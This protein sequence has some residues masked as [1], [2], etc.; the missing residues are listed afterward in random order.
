MP[1]TTKQPTGEYPKPTPAQ[2]ID[3]VETAD[4]L[5]AG[6]A[7]KRRQTQSLGREAGVSVIMM[8]MEGGD[9]LAEHS[10]KGTVTAHVLRG[11]VTLAAAGE[12]FDLR[13]GQLVMMQPG[14]RHD[15]RAEEQSVVLLTIDGGDE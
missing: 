10:A 5:V 8:A 2:R 6:L 1:E 14:V 7:G 3:L 11:H 12:A 13:P 15:V 4:R 9:L